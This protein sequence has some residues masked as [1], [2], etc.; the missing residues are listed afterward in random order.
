MRGELKQFEFI[1]NS[2]KIC[3]TLFRCMCNYMHP[4]IFHSNYPDVTPVIK[5]IDLILFHDNINVPFLYSKQQR[6]I[7]NCHF[8][9]LC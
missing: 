7:I 4:K 3:I 1:E 6:Y 9:K 8:A 5:L 2:K